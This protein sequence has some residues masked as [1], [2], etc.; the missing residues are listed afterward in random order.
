V[1]SLGNGWSCH[2]GRTAVVMVG[3]A[4]VE[5]S[6][7]APEELVGTLLAVAQAL[8]A[9]AMEAA[10]EVEAPLLPVG[11]AEATEAEGS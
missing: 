11:A 4:E 3:T 9:A 2:L 8:R 7:A 1:G 5:A 10:E 6:A